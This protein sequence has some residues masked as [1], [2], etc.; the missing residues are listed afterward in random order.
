MQNFY[1]AARTLADIPDLHAGGTALIFQGRHTSYP[2]LAQAANRMANAMA[3]QG[4]APGARVGFLGLDSDKSYEILFGCARAAMV[5][6]PVNWK[7]TAEE[8]EFIVRDAE[9]ELLFVTPETAQPA[10]DL[11]ARCPR[12]RAVVVIGGAAAG[13][14]GYA[15]L[16]DAAPA[17]RPAVPIE[18]GTPVVQI[19]TSGT[20]GKP[21]GVV[22]GHRGF[23]DTVREIVRASDEF[24]EWTPRDVSLLTL[25]TFHVGG[26]WWAM[27]GLINGAANVVMKA[28]DSAEAL[29]AIAQYRITKLAFVPAMLRFL[30][31]DPAC[32]ATDLSSVD[33]I[34][35]GGAPMALPLLDKAQA[36]LRCRFAHNY[37]MSETTNMAIFMPPSEH[38]AA[39]GQ[40]RTSAGRP[41]RGVRVR[42]VDGEGRG[43]APGESGE[44]HFHTPTRMLEYW[45]RPEATAETLVD[46]WIHTGDAGYMDEDGYLYITDRIK[47][48]VISAGENISPAE[49]E[50]VL[51]THPAIDEAA[52]IGVPDKRW[53]E[54]PIAYVVPVSGSGLTRADVMAHARGRIASFKM[55]YDAI[56]VERLPRNATGKVLKRVLREP[57]WA[58][59]ER[60]VN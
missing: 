58:G 30:L 7:L 2:D 34:I 24:I 29:G 26:L 44:I 55:I 41:V 31:S 25:P 47:D 59:Q 16:R 22:L 39:T 43:L 5:F 45:K 46:G 23:I 14:T 57:H 37:G 8:M 10:Q 17:V 4:L 18:P 36:R 9:C 42:I 13:L 12:L 52:V 19:Y 60:Q 33:F 54:V 35:Y 51:L 50:Q 32:A 40:R 6:V 28:F 3:A 1:D 38:A 49:L 21:K 53:G 11:R 27:Q 56:L 20:S 15:G 48:V